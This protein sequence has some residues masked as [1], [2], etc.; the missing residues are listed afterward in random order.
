MR[1]YET[2]EMGNVIKY[3]TVDVGLCL[4]VAL[5]FALKISRN[6]YC[7]YLH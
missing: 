2:S 5:V 6:T 1:R 4:V 3:L 7:L